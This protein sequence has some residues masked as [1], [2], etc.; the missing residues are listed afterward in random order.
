MPTYEQHVDFLERACPDEKVVQIYRD[1][2]EDN[3]N[4][5]LYGLQMLFGLRPDETTKAKIRMIGVKIIAYSL[6]ISK[7]PSSKE[8]YR[9]KLSALVNQWIELVEDEPSEI[10]NRIWLSSAL[11]HFAQEPELAVR[12]AV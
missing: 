2:D 3:I 1:V 5:A 7:D 4:M 10:Y 12:L 8:Q 9:D 11:E 6:A